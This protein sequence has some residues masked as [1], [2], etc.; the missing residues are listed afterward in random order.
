MTTLGS[1]NAAAGTRSRHWLL[2][3]VGVLLVLLGPAVYAVQLSWHYLKT[4]WYVPI[5][6][7]CG[8]LLMAVSVWRR[9]G[10]VRGAGLVL[11]LLVCGFEWFFVLVA[12]RTPPYTG[13]AQP[14]QHIPA[15]AT[16]LANGTPFT[17][18]DLEN[19]KPTVLVFY[20]GHW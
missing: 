17:S 9:P 7:S 2:F 11:F 12:L 3:L 8:V 6:A 14:N 10:L 5:L 20:R 1:A 15:F 13:P 16:T 4:P 19:G 18:K